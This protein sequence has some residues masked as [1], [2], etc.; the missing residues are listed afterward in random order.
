MHDV[1]LVDSQIP[2]EVD[3]W[4][5]TALHYAAEGGHEDSV[6]LLL[7]INFDVNLQDRSGHT[8]LML[9]AREARV[10]VVQMLIQKHADVNARNSEKR[11][12]LHQ[13]CEG[14]HSNL[15]SRTRLTHAFQHVY[16]LRCLM[17]AHRKTSPASRAIVRP[18]PRLLQR[19]WPLCAERRQ[20]EKCANKNPPH[21]PD[22]R[23]HLAHLPQECRPLHERVQKRC[24]WTRPGH[25]GNVTQV[26]CCHAHDA[27]ERAA[28]RGWR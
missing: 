28:R 15:P 26:P 22:P 11:T 20:N 2:W 7:E 8:A 12:A 3:E 6:E 25:D 16:G 5:N 24:L 17:G 19:A 27:Q 13:V 18:R 14:G 10:N 21:K 1:T 4:G 23:C 9:A